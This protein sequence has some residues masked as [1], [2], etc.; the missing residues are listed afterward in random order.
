MKIL[1]TGATGYIGHQLALAA[2]RK[3]HCVHALV[4]NPASPA[5]PRHPDIRAFEGDITDRSSVEAAVAGCDA[6]FHAAAITRFHSRDR[7]HFYRVNVE[8]TR[9]LLEAGLS[10]GVRKFVFTSSGAVLGPSLR[11]PL[12]ESDPRITAFENDYEIS[13]FMAEESVREFVTKGLDAVI[14]AAPRVYGPGPAVNG[15][16]FGR[17]LHRILGMGMAFIPAQKNVLA[18]YAYIDDVVEGHFA[19]LEKGRQGEK[20]ILGGENLSYEDFFRHLRKHAGQ[21]IRLVTVPLPV[22]KAWSFFHQGLCR[23]T[24]RES[25]ISPAVVRRLT[26]NRALSCEKAVKELGYR[27]TPFEE[28]IKRTFYYLKNT[29][30]HEHK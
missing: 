14:V 26:V 19:A 23:L 28:G 27:I 12:T 8:A 16:V 21:P 1:I 2:V 10:A 18:N 20:Y 17:L 13:K 3:G 11:N 5:F 25:N 22:L 6:I 15:N 4:R 30:C 7:K 24:G 9:L 29:S